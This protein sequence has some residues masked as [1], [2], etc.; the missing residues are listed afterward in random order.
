MFLCLADKLDRFITAL[1]FAKDQN[2]SSHIKFFSRHSTSFVPLD[3]TV[4]TYKQLHKYASNFS[5]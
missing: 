1:W 2:K 5:T 3:G 4:L